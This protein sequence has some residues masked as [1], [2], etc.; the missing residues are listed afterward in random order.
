MY[1]ESLHICDNCQTLWKLEDLTDIDN[2]TF[3]FTISPG[4]PMPSGG[5]PNEATCDGLWCYPEDKPTQHETLTKERDHL[6]RILSRLITWEGIMGGFEASVWDEAREALE[7][8]EV[9]I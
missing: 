2:D 9:A 7:Q 4:D 1:R 3:W 6:A 5:C 8:T